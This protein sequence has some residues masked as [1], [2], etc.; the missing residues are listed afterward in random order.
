MFS[1]CPSKYLHPFF[2]T[3]VYLYTVGVDAPEETG[4]ES[5]CGGVFS[6]NPSTTAFSSVVFGRLSSVEPTRKDSK[7]GRGRLMLRT[8]DTIERNDQAFSPR[9]FEQLIGNSPALEELL[10]H[11]KRVA[12]TDSAVLIQVEAGT[13]K[14]LIARAIHN[15]SSRCGRPFIKLNCAA[16]HGEAR[17]RRA[18]GTDRLVP[19]RVGPSASTARP[20][21]SAMPAF[22]PPSCATPKRQ[23]PTMASIHA[24][25]S[26]RSANGTWSAVRRT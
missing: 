17:F 23:A 4:N 2:N 5:R 12:P 1:Q 10:E 7:E 8:F 26:W 22:I 6:Q 21:A 25:S 13:G 15:I 11:V 18:H 20:S 3:S 16:I 9:R 14:Q 19:E 24:P